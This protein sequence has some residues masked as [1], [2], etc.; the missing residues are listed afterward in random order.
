MSIESAKRLTIFIKAVMIL[1]VLGGEMMENMKYGVQEFIMTFPEDKREDFIAC[2]MSL[3]G[4]LEWVKMTNG[5]RK[6]ASV[7]FSSDINALAILLS[8]GAPVDALLDEIKENS[9]DSNYKKALKNGKKV[10]DLFSKIKQVESEILAK[11]QDVETLIWRNDESIKALFTLYK[12]SK[13]HF[14]AFSI[15]CDGLW[16][17]LS[18]NGVFLEYQQTNPEEFE[19]FMNQKYGGK[20]AGRAVYTE[21]KNS[22]IAFM[23]RGL[24]L[25]LYCRKGRC[26]GFNNFYSAVELAMDFDHEFYLE[27][28]EKIQTMDEFY[29][30]ALHDKALEFSNVI[31]K[32]H[33]DENEKTISQLLMYYVNEINVPYDD[34]LKMVTAKAKNPG[35]EDLATLLPLFKLLEHQENLVYSTNRVRRNFFGESFHIEMYS[36]EENHIRETI[37]GVLITNDDYKYVLESL[38][39]R[40]I[41]AVKKIVYFAV[42]KHVLDKIDSEETGAVV[43]KNLDDFL[44]YLT[45]DKALE[46]N[47]QKAMV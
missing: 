12:E 28:K 44:D 25:K 32:F 24:P 29:E 40:G 45:P 13:L 22:L 18:F 10:T 27:L 47:K 41:P 9:A 30:N 11:P 43:T 17:R 16:E 46:T 42:R 19:Q 15:V 14:E 23:N 8:R 36:L 5:D 31:Q 38:A 34:F 6:L 1:G 26:G 7:V 4:T 37:N 33:T 21:K 3:K 35:E 39:N 20:R 2:L